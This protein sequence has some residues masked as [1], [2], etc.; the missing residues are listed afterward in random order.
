LDISIKTQQ[1]GYILRYI[2]DAVVYHDHPATVKGL[3]FQQYRN[4]IGFV[5]LHRKY[6]QK[7]NLAYNTS[8]SW[9]RILLVLLRYPFTLISALVLKKKKY[10]VLKPLYYVI[11]D[12]AFSWAVIRETLWGKEYR[13]YP[14]QSRIDTIRFMEN[15]PMSFLLQKI[16][17]KVRNY[18]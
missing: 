16:M 1:L 2:P 11:Y 15:K 17:K 8:I 13:K 12:G 7:Y 9:G 10:S 5:R 14:I 6:G 3:F 4:G 18:S